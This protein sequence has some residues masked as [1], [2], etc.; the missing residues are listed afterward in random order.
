YRKRNRWRHSRR[1]VAVVLDDEVPPSP[2]EPVPHRTAGYG[3][4]HQKRKLQIPDRSRSVSPLRA[5]S[6]LQTYDKYA[7]YERNRTDSM[8]RYG[9]Q[10]NGPGFSSPQRS[11]TDERPPHRT[12]ALSP[13]SKV[14]API[15]RYFK[16]KECPTKVPDILCKAH[17]TREREAVAGSIDKR[18]TSINNTDATSHRASRARAEKYVWNRCTPPPLHLHCN[19]ASLLCSLLKT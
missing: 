5:E 16:G 17:A 18:W 11:G 1:P 13:A 15:D 7:K 19:I 6:P 9:T 8:T 10:W 14:P 4:A 2:R 3:L 12:P